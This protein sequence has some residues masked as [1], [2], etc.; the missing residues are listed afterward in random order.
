MS[1]FEGLVAVV[2]G[3]ASGIGAATARELAGRGARVAII[4]RAHPEPVEGIF[5]ATADLTAD[6]E[7]RDAVDRIGTELG[8]IDILVNNAGIGAV[9]DVGA[10][11][12]DEW[13]RVYDVNVVGIA[14]VTR[15]ALPWL[16]ESPSAAIVNTASVAG[17]NGLPQRALYSATKGLSSHSPTPWRP[18]FWLTAS[19]STPSRRGRLIRRG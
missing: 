18:I 3:G 7:I 16:R 12:D 4:D 5:R 11:E 13:H 15:H 9:G 2:T 8:G 6:A 10:N 19:A 17:T 14:R 1:D